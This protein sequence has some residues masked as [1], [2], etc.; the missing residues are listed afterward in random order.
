MHPGLGRGDAADSEDPGLTRMDTTCGAVL[1]Q[2]GCL[3][4]VAQFLELAQ[5]TKRNLGLEHRAGPECTG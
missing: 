1:D 5:C 4:R 2:F 3:P